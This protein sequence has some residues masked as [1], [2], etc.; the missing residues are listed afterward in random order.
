MFDVIT[1]GAATRDVFLISKEFQIINSPQFSTGQGECVALGSKIDVDNIVFS[2]GGGATNAAATFAKLGFAT[3]IVTRIGKDDPGTAI[4][5]E[6]SSFGVNTELIYVATKE[7]T[8]Y[9]TLL[10]AKNG[11]RSVL[12]YRGASSSFTPRDIPWKNL[13][14]QW[15]YVTSL[16]G[17]I[18]LLQKLLVHAKKHNIKVALNPGR[19]ELKRA[20]ELR[21]LLSSLSVLIVNVEE[22]QML[23]ETEEKDGAKLCKLLAYP[24]LHVIVTNGSRGAHAHK[25]GQTW[26]ARTSGAKSVSRTGAGDAFGSGA[27]AALAK[28]LELDIAL[29]IGTMNA[30]SVI[31]S[32]GAKTGILK[33][34]PT[35][36]QLSLIS[37]KLV[38]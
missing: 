36:Q 22:A 33:K 26:F 32:F 11:E 24:G 31:Q 15:L 28:N 12:V 14:A 30:E 8:A 2:T 34:W 29:K 37:V 10:T 6:L 35:K 9:S 3:S 18:E 16:A 1:I 23:T 7:T 19:G 21:E 20:V 17:N 13:S 25:D 38:K 27:V 4:T 5:T